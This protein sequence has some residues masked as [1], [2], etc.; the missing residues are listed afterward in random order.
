ML[1]PHG[2][3]KGLLGTL[4]QGFPLLGPTGVQHEGIKLAVTKVETCIFTLGRLIH[5]PEPHKL[6]LIVTTLLLLR[7]ITLINI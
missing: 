6:K 4:Q 2:I 1:N 5:F 7:K 3:K